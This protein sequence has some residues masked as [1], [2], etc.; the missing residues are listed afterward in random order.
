MPTKC[1]ATSRIILFTVHKIAPYAEQFSETA[2]GTRIPGV[3]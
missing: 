2:Q 3:G 1:I